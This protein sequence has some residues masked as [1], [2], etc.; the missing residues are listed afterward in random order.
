MDD[1]PEILDDRD[2]RLRPLAG[3]DLPEIARH[4]NDPRVARWLAAVTQPFDPA[5]L[6]RHGAHP[7][8][9]LRV[10]VS[11]D[12][13]I[14]GLCLGASLWYWLAPEFWGHGHMQRALTLAIRAR[15][16]RSAPPIVATCHEDN[17]A[18]RALLTRLGFA[19]LPNTR[20]MFFHGTQRSEP[21]RDYLLAPEQWH[22]LH[23][24]T[25]PAGRT[26]LRPA[27]QKD[28]PA[29]ALMLPRAGQGPWPEAETLPG[30]IET[31]RFR[32]GEKG[33]FVIVDENRRTCGM[34]LIG[35]DPHMRFLSDEDDA[36]HR[37]A[38][39]AALDKGLFAVPQSFRCA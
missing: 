37:D 2:L 4:L 24:P 17:A 31:H 7:G 33:L 16:A 23:P 35:K 13:V 30:F 28:A 19:P 18:S 26:T 32:G 14:G 21:C 20:R 22:L 11:S 34:A 15:F 27:A 8:E 39:T 1:F 10:I 9:N 5:E 12:A 38:V 6:L 29:L 36:K 25:F 3:T